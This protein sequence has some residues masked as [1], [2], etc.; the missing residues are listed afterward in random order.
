MKTSVLIRNARLADGSAPVDILVSGGV[1][2]AK[3]PAGTLSADSAEKVL[4]ASGKLDPSTMPTG[5]GQDAKTVLTS[6]ALTIGPVNIYNNAGVANVRKADATAEGKE[7][8]GFVIAAFGSGVNATVFFEGRITGLSGLT[9]GARYY[10]YPLATEAVSL[11]Y[12]LDLVPV[13]PRS[14]A[15]VATLDRRLRAE[16]KR[17]IEWDYRNL[18]FSWPIIAGIVA[19]TLANEAGIIGAAKLA[20]DAQKVRGRHSS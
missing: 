7:A 8:N 14:L 11:I 18:Y 17:A 6:E 4:D 19:A 15:E 12:N 20:A 2:A 9:I 3:V 16:G 1:I 10:G 13:P 5:V